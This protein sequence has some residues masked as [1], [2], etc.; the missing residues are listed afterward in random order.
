MTFTCNFE[1]CLTKEQE[2][3]IICQ[4]EKEGSVWGVP[5]FVS[6]FKKKRLS[7]C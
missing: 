4:G 5:I 3:F 2:H 6:K 1:I 7:A